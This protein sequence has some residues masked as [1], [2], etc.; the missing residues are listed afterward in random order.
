[1]IQPRLSAAVLALFGFALAGCVSTRPT[2]LLR[3]VE[4]EVNRTPAT[5]DDYVTW[6]PTPCRIR[7]SSGSSTASSV[8]VVLGNED[9]NAGGQLLFADASLPAG[10]TAILGSLPLTLPGDAVFERPGEA[11]A[12]FRP[13]FEALLDDLNTPLALAALHE[14]VGRINR[15]GSDAERSALQKALERGGRLLGLLEHNP[16]DWLRGSAAADARRIEERIA[17]RAE[18]RR[19]R[20]FAEADRIRAELA[21]EGVI[22]EDKPDGT[23]AWWRKE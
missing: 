2:E 12:A 16:L 20:R 15:T 10:Q 1:M 23:T 22:L 3:V 5:I 7:L 4:V 13:V 21:R 18:A 11:D 9:A 6:A 19:A 8:N 17:A 14:L